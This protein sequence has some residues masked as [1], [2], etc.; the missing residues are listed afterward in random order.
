MMPT[1]KDGEKVYVTCS[2]TMEINVDD[3]ILYS[4]YEL[5]LTIHRVVET[6][7]DNGIAIYRTKG[8]GNS[9]FDDYSLT[10]EEIVGKVINI[11]H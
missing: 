7:V 5:H 3:I 6:C 9:E 11:C 2:R 1:F 4:K 10:R 8:D